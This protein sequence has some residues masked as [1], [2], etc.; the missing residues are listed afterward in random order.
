ML[1]LLSLTLTCLLF[2]G[3]AATNDLNGYDEV[4]LVDLEP[5]N[6]ML[7]IGKRHWD[8][9]WGIEGYI[10]FRKSHYYATL[11]GTGPTFTNPV[12]EDSPPFPC[13]G[14]ITL[15]REHGRVTIKL[16]RVISEEGKPERRESH[17]ANGTYPLKS[18]TKANYE[19]GR[20]VLP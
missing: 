6:M 5:G 7:S 8:G 1:R 14:M 3:C 4:H 16:Q 10:G 12:F 18:V 15:D 19:N 11:E 17:P 13:V 20:L 9:F 2:A